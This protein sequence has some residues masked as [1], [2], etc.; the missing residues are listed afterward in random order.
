MLSIFVAFKNITLTGD[1]KLLSEVY[2]L[3]EGSSKHPF[4]YCTAEAQQLAKGQPRTLG[5]LRNDYQRWKSNSGGDK[6][7]CKDY[8][9]VKNP[10]LLQDMPNEVP[11][12]K[13]TPPPVLHIMLGIFNHIWKNIE[14]L[15]EE[16]ERV[17][18]EFAMR[19]NCV[20]ESYW[21]KTFEGNECVKLMNKLTAEDE[22]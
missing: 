17:L 11:I 8:N 22:S 14:N 3:M 10:P 7:S 6:K 4:L 15:S 9:N 21:G 16:H 19:H 13:I 5:S 20:K 1:L 18:H 2:G 12:L